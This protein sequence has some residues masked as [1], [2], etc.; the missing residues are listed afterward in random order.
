[1]SADKTP[2]TLEQ[3]EAALLKERRRQAHK[4]DADCAS[5]RGADGECHCERDGV[6]EWCVDCGA[7]FSWAQTNT[8]SCCPRC[9]SHSVP[10]AAI[11]D[12]DVRI[13][14]H[15]LRNMVMWAEQWAHKCDRDH[16]SP[17]HQPPPGCDRSDYRHLLPTVRAIAARLA[18]QHPT[19]DP[20]TF[21]GEL[22]AF[23]R[24]VPQA[25]I[26]SDFPPDDSGSGP[27]LQ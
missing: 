16:E 5:L 7:K 25:E 14:W 15:E 6:F 1:M 22:A 17:A 8:L 4:H 20:L 26:V 27:V 21:S 18:G 9:G 23:Q 10:C 2:I 3:L 19:R 11:D 24:Q 12:V 13:N